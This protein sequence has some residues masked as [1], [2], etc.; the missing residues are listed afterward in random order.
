MNIQNLSIQVIPINTES[1]YTH[2][3]AAIAVIQSSGLR[4]EVTPFSTVVEGSLEALQ[5]LITVIQTALFDQGVEEVIL[6]IQFHAK[7]S[8]DVF[9]HEKTDKFQWVGN[10]KKI[11]NGS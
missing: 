5:N 8:K 7:K 10:F 3:D 11:V 9:L 6:N 2:I 1:A 4:Y